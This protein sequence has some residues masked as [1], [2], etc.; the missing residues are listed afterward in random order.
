MPTRRAATKAA[1]RWSSGVTNESPIFNCRTM[2][3][4]PLPPRRGGS[5]VIGMF[6]SILMFDTSVGMPELIRLVVCAGE[7]LFL[8]GFRAG[9]RNVSPVRGSVHE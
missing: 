7:V 1:L 5:G 4:S 3:A 6:R 2:C 8:R 9:G